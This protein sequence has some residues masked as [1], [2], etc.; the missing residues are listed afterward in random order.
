MSEGNCS[1]YP[2]ADR[3]NRLTISSSQGT[4]VSAFDIDGICLDYQPPSREFTTS[5]PDLHPFICVHHELYNS[6]HSLELWT[7]VLAGPH[8]GNRVGKR[9]WLVRIGEDAILD[10]PLPFSFALFFE[11]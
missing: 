8:R 1:S 7:H 2:A 11:L 5:S 4:F 10:S 6:F 9:G 3:R